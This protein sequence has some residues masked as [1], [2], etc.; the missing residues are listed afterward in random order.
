VRRRL[1][2][3]I[4]AAWWRVLARLGLSRERWRALPRVARRAV[5]AVFWV[6]VGLLLVAG[7]GVWQWSA[8]AI[9]AVI[10]VLVVPDYSR[11][12]IGGK[13]VGRFVVPLAVLA[14]AFTYPFYA[15]S[16]TGVSPG[17]PQ[18][19]IFGTL[20]LMSTMVNMAIFTMMAL[21]LNFVVGYAG[22]LDLGYVAFF[23]MGSYMAG[24]LA[25][26][27][28]S[29]VNV[30]FG[31]IGVIPGLTGI[32]ISIWL[33]LLC[34]GIA[35]AFTGIVIGLPT[36]RLRGDYLAIVTLGFGEILP[37]VARNG[38]SLGGF[39]LTNGTGGITPIDPPGFG[40]WAHQ[41]LGL[42]SN[43][44]A[45]GTTFDRDYF[46]TVLVLVLI[47]I[48]CSA[49]L[50]DSRLGRAW[51]AIR[52]DEV[53]AAAMGVPLMKTKTWAYATGAFFGGVAG[54]YYASYNSSSN[55]DEFY[56]QISVFILV[57]VILGGMGSIPGVIFGACF[58]TYLNSE[59][60]NNIG[61]WLNGHFGPG[62]SD[63]QLWHKPLDVP[64]YNFGI[65]GVIL[66]VV[67]LVR[68]EGLIPSRRRAAE[69]HEG[70]HDQPL[71][72]VA[73]A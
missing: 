31:G 41:H 1:S 69:F 14:I 24:W 13:R 73:E 8:L 30:R 18:L 57:M 42:P 17:L 28:F 4:S 37:Q 55:P 59:G 22:L 68:P 60:L 47:T 40:N 15:Y 19:P 63:V 38:D 53:A 65:Y 58:L 72:D 43:Y 2:G 45:L 46:W 66:V 64:L 34:A 44:G 5:K 29:Q 10:L 52:E 67:M 71:Y 12:T 61:A 56:F 3:A 33:V 54:A 9:A 11:L 36:L 26:G 25:S 50:R 27:Q 16:S 35:T 62:G 23:A 70:V 21:G 39:N 20:P 6:V 48:F 7:L 32:H 49:R 51:I